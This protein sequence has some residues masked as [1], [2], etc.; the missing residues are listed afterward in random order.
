MST[1]PIFRSYSVCD[2]KENVLILHRRYG[3][4]CSWGARLALPIVQFSVGHSV[5]LVVVKCAVVYFVIL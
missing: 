4:G 1:Q 3:V 2:E 5:V